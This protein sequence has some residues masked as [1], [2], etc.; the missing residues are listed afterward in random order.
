MKILMMT[1]PE[2]EV[3]KTGLSLREKR[4]P[5]G[6]GYVMGALLSQG[7]EIDFIDQYLDPTRDF[8]VSDYN[9]IGIYCNTPCWEGT[10]KLLE[11]INHW[12]TFH[13]KLIVGGPHATLFP[14][15]I[16][17]FVDFIVQGE[18]EEVIGDIIEGKITNRIIKTSRIL[19]L[20]TLPKP[21][22]EAF[23]HLPYKVDVD[24]FPET[25]VFTMNVSRGCPH[26][27]SFCSVKK[28]W[29]RKYTYFSTQRVLSDI[30]WLIETFFI[31]GIYFREDNFTIKRER[32]KEISIGLATR[33]LKWLC[34]T[35]VDTLDE[36]LIKVMSNS[37]CKAFYIGFE[38]GSQ[39]MLNTYNKGI[40]IEQGLQV[41]EWC[42]KYD[43]KIAASFII[44]H[45]AET[46]EDKELTEKFIKQINPH[47]I[48]KNKY[49]KEG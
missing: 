41:A 34:E 3:N 21:A 14:E 18:G 19:D 9:F 27:C 30:D 15:T 29:G 12:K 46:Q 36:E 8:S 17:D 25:P 45:P 32:T 42:H 49:R 1:S 4:F 26:N 39:R 40:T 6:L 22:Y 20:D 33:N 11:H 2:P 28:L 38:S 48:W 7:Y 10:K 5:L 24:W 31:K 43:I 47:T 37:G 44:N 16:P 35:R 23:S 13:T